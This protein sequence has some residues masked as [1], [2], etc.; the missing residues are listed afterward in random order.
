MMRKYL[1]LVLAGCCG[2]TLVGQAAQA[3]AA[4][5]ISD[6][7][8]VR[9]LSGDDLAAWNAAAKKIADGQSEVD[10]GK[11]FQASVAG[12]NDVDKTDL[13]DTHKKGDDMVKAGTALIKDGKAT[14]DKLRKI[15]IA[16][17]DE[18]H[19]QIAA[20]AAADFTAAAGQWPEAIQSM[21]AKLLG[22]LWDQQYTR[23]YF[24]GVFAF[25]EPAYVA[26][27]DLSAQLRDQLRLL[28]TQKKTVEYPSA[29]SL[30]VAQENGK[31]IVDYPERATNLQNG[32]KAALII[33][34]VLYETRDGYAAF[35]LRAVDLSNLH[36]VASQVMMLSVE[37]ATAKLLG[38]PAFRVMARREAPPAPALGADGKPVDASS[39]GNSP[40]AAPPVAISVN[41]QDPNDTLASFKNSN[42][43]FRLATSGHAKTLENRFAAL[44]VKGYFVDQQPGISI[45]DQD[46][47]ALA[48]PADADGDAAASA[49]DVNTAWVLPNVSDLNVPSIEIAPLVARD[50]QNN[51][52]VNIGKLTIERTLPK[53][54]IP[55]AEELRAAGY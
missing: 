24:G 41:L 44:M 46:F 51:A 31:L 22:R 19:K 48:L 8:A 7:D 55:S 40:P 47:L 26:K 39:G 49:A 4:P 3:P 52:Q 30:K 27:P 25:E 53:L 50:L 34:E 13:A 12:P 37:P 15:A 28:D 43:V 33:G 6:A 11:L 5:A 2:C 17:R 1:T 29:D 14:E 20:T 45:S 18:E 16:K 54:S 23:I 9:Y 10:D 35:S 42:Y 32:A 38:L 36:I 21:S